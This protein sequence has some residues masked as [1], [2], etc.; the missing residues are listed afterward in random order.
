MT[1]SGFAP[2]TS[3][4]ISFW[5]CV[6]AGQT[7]TPQ[8]IYTDTVTMTVRMTPSSGGARNY[9][10]TFP[11]AIHRGA[12]CSISNAP[13]S[14]ALNYTSFGP[15]A[16]ANT[17]FGA[18]CTNQLPYTMSLDTTSGTLLGLNYS[19]ALSAASATGTGVEQTYTITGTMAAGQVG[20]CAT[21]TCSASQPHTLTIN[22]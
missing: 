1:L 16:N 9:T 19:L 5:G 17:T 18:T 21:T 11:V 4:P 6:P 12:S 10:G 20:T 7:S 8:G 13:G 15:P 3:P 14:V 22:Y 2:T